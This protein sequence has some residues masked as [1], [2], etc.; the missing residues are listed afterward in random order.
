LVVV[1]LLSLIFVPP[2]LATSAPK[3]NNGKKW[4]IGYYEGGAYSDYAKTMRTLILGLMDLGWINKTNFPELT[5]E[6]PKPY[7][8]WLIQCDSPYLSFSAEDSYSADWDDKKRP[9]IREKLM[10]KLRSGSIDL[11]IA[12]GTW[13]GLDLANDE[14]SIPVMVL[15]TSDPVRAGIL[16]SEK[17]S[18]YDHVTARVDSDRYL[19]QIRMFHRIVGFKKLGI[20]YEDTPDGRIYSAIH[21]VYRIAEERGYKVVSCKVT[22]TTSDTQISDRSCLDCYRQLAQE[23]DAV[24]ITALSCVD[25]KAEEI[26]DLLRTQKTPSFAMVG[27]N[28]VKKGM[29]LSISSDSGYTALGRYNATKFGKILNGATPRKL[30]QVLKDPLEIAVNMET[31]RQVGFK[32][33]DS[34]LKIASEIYEE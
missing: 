33:P 30:N 27:S 26:S 22:D 34:I 18:G 1:F 7:I 23:S 25:R 17:D 6:T 32:M 4:R 19:R 21:E 16:K 15:S 13:A 31:V 12:M 9:R 28:F 14:H 10:K 24:Y 20:A 3:L 11:I 29:M 8:D 2:L 5:D